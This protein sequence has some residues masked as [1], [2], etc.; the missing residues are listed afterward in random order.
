MSNENIAER[1]DPTQRLPRQANHYAQIVGHFLEVKQ[2]KQVGKAMAAHFQRLSRYHQRLL[3]VAS[4]A[5]DETTEDEA[6]D[7]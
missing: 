2:S 6:T 1:R 5:E 4:S 7:D 3:G